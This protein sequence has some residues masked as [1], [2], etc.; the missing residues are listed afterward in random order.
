MTKSQLVADVGENRPDLSQPPDDNW[1]G[2]GLH[3]ALRHTSG[4]ERRFR[5]RGFANDSPAWWEH[6]L[7]ERD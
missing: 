6:K 3:G 5:D 4:L 1:K 7:K 2:A